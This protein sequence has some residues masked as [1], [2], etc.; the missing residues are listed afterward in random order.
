[1][2]EHAGLGVELDEQPA[3]A[4][5]GVVDE[6]DAL[7]HGAVRRAHLAADPRVGSGGVLDDDHDV[8][9][10]GLGRR[11]LGARRERQLS[12]STDAQAVAERCVQADHAER[13]RCVGDGLARVGHPVRRRVGLNAPA[14]ERASVAIAHRAGNDGSRVESEVRVGHGTCCAGDGLR[15][16]AELGVLG[17]RRVELLLAGATRVSS[18]WPSAPVVARGAG[19]LSKYQPPPC[20]C[21]AMTR[22]PATGS[23]S[24][25][26]TTPTTR[27]GSWSRTSNAVRSAITSTWPDQSGQPVAITDTGWVPSGTPR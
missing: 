3:A 4:V 20:S 25:S 19:K 17:M 6:V 16:L 11:Q 23:P 7:G 14:G 18:K 2:L 10:A 13:T 21:A 27:A 26:R 1:M 22:A 12:G 8:Q 9:L 24:A 15:R 5:L